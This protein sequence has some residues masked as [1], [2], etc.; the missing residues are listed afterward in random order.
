MWMADPAVTTFPGSM[1]LVYKSRFGCGGATCSLG[2]DTK[3]VTCNNNGTYSVCLNYGGSAGRWAIKDETGQAT[4]VSYT[5]YLQD[6]TTVAATGSNPPTNPLLMTFGTIANNEAVFGTIC[7]TYPLG[8]AYDI[9]LTPD[10]TFSYGTGYIQCADGD[11]QTGASAV[12][13]T[14][15]AVA[16]PTSIDITSAAH[17]SDL[18]V[19]SVSPGAITDYTYLWEIVG[20]SNGTLTNA[21]SA[22]ATYTAGILDAGQ[23]INFKVTATP[24]DASVCVQT[25][26]VAVDVSN[27]GRC[28]VTGPTPICSG[29]TNT[30]TGAP[31]PVPTNATYLW[32]LSG[33]GG[34]GSTDATFASANGLGTIDVKAGTQGYRITLQQTYANTDLNTECFEDVTVGA[35]TADCSTTPALC[36]GAKDGTLTAIPG[37]GTSPYTFSIDGTNFQSS[38]SFTGLGQGTYTLTVMDANGCTATHDCTVGQPST[39]T[40]D[41]ST[42]PASCNGAKDGTLTA[43]P[44]GG[45]S[46][47]TFSIDGTNFQS[48]TSFTGLGQGTYTLT[49][50][51]A[52][53]CTATHDCTVGQPSTV[54]ADCSTTP[55]SCNGAKDG[56]LTAIPGGGT[57]PYTFS[58]DG[59]NFQSSTS[60][61]GLGQVPYTLTVMDAHGCTATHDCTVGQPSTVTADCSTTPASCNGAKDGTL[62][63]IPGRRNQSIYILNRWYQLP[64]INKLYRPGPG[65][66]H[67]DCDG[68]P[69]LYRNT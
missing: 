31:N 19:T 69:W 18:K 68:C 20:G 10:P 25:A 14:V 67:P 12:T 23:T 1:N 47:Y 40:A 22:T 37:G 66:L 64:V 51:D 5:T 42:T 6:G 8:T 52:H 48:S 54:T 15:T 46:P 45:T 26:T 56:T 33:F 28:G 3:K 36:N 9:S 32:V 4:S 57:S 62:T 24:K 34:S 38:T 43:I 53:G 35:V 58:I 60:F 17:S 41:C 30:Y 2:F 27:I 21:T 61:T 55:A 59:T 39:V 7:A 29:S 50:M 49:V 13:A 16:D 65:Y 11:R 44:G 63:A